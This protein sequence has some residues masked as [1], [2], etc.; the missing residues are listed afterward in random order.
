MLYLLFTINRPNGTLFKAPIDKTER[1]MERVKRGDVVTFT[2]ESHKRRPIP[3]NPLVTRIRRDFHWP[4]SSSLYFS[5]SP[6]LSFSSS[7]S[8]SSSLPQKGMG[9]SKVERGRQKMRRF[10]EKVAK[11]I[12]LDPLVAENWYSIPRKQL[13][14]FKV[15]ISFFILYLLFLLCSFT[16]FNLLYYTGIKNVHAD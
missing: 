13:M 7:P 4:L 12:G 16:L 8:L 14:Q 3:S 10:L 15:Y 1:E 6:S 5:S 2:Y 11:N 9:E